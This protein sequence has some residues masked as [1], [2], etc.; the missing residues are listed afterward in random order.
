AFQLYD[1]DN[2]QT[3]TYDEMLSI[4]DAI[5]KMVGTMVK[6][7]PDEDTPEKRVSKI[8]SLMD[9]DKDGRL[10]FD[11]FKEGSMKDPTIVQ[12]LS[13]YDGLLRNTMTDKLL[14]LFCVVDGEAT[15]FSV[16]VASTD[17][18]HDLKKAVKAAKAPRF[19]DVAA[20]ELILWHISIRI[21]PPKE[22]GP[23][24][25]NEAESPTELDPSDDISEVFPEIPF[26]KT[27][28]VIVQRPP[29]D[30]AQSPTHPITIP[31]G[32]PK[33]DIK[34]ITE[35]FFAPGSATTIFL[36]RF[37][38]G[39]EKLP[40]TTGRVAGLPRVW[41]RKHAPV[42]TRP[43]LL[44]ANLP[45]SSLSDT[46]TRYPTS[47]AILEHIEKCKPSLVLIFGV[48]G[49]GK[50][51][52]M[53]ELLSRRWGF[54]FNASPKDLGSSDIT[55]L[56]DHIESRT[57][58]DRL[59]NN[60]EARIVTYLLLLSRLK[61]LQHCLAVPGS[62]QTFTSA[63]WTILQ[64]CPH[65]FN[66]DLFNLLFHTFLTLSPG[67]S[68]RSTEIDLQIALQEEIQVT[69]DLL[70]KHGRQGGLP[71]F[72]YNDN[73]LVVFDEAQILGDTL[74]GRFDSFSP[75]IPEWSLLTLV[76]EGVRNISYD[77][78]V[79]TSGNRLSIYTQTCARSSGLF[80][81]RTDENEHQYMEFP[82]WTGRE[83]IESYVVGLR[84]LL[85]TDDSK[86]ALNRLLQP[87][88]I[89]A[90]SN[91]LVGRFRPAVTA[92]ETIIA[93]G[94]SNQWQ[95][96]IDETEAHLVS[97]DH[98]QKRG[99][100]CNE[101]VRLQNKYDENV[102]PF[103]DDQRVEEVLGPLLFQRYMFGADALVFRKVIPELV[104]HGFSRIKTIDGIM[105]SVLD[106]PF[107]LKAVENYFKNQDS[108]FMKS[109][110]H[111]VMQSDKAQVH[112]YA[113]ELMMMDVLVE[114]FKTHAL[115]DW[116]HK[117]SISSQCSALKGHAL[118]VGLDEQELK[119]GIS[120]EHITMER[121]LDAHLNKDSMLDGCAVPPFFFPK[122][123]PAG[124]DIV[125]CIRVQNQLFPV[126][127]Q[128]KLRQIMTTENLR[129]AVKTASAPAV[130]DHVESLG[131]CCT[132]NKTFI[133]MMIA[134]PSEVVDKL[135]PRRGI[136]EKLDLRYKKPSDLTHVRIMIDSENI[137]EIFPKSH[138]EFLDVM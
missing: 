45:H 114:I 71:S 34:G 3:I 12:A 109:L 130:E 103:V 101:V 51:R 77:L 89:Q 41:L 60:R 15:L 122:A 19:D 13:L 43:S 32:N 49:C 73:L 38:Q 78:T 104:E 61:I 136:F 72:K 94:K 113:W 97:Y 46:Q 39:L 50:T 56:V 20:D 92:I 115:S 132:T 47:D 107:V 33:A 128:L 68:T 117:P 74:K 96:V 138:V 24:V 16:K 81:K 133:S 126:F 84:S 123:K 58:E 11:E 22:R 100:L 76:L 64:T 112:G 93:S 14:T 70:V 121:F 118:I 42:D 129:D 119:R 55:L 79:V 53:I 2:D 8:F 65:I 21:P 69:K 135:Y 98:Q 4:V 48:S 125:F 124:P 67:D 110:Q 27:I 36:D 57:Q 137:N 7:P 102:S 111:W 23:F 116:P 9:K 5:Y 134:Y 1:I 31:S 88:A 66:N 106:E 80:L 40:L 37:V 87:E 54:Y 85:P 75:R 82:G 120:H 90:M 44:F 6:L 28:H 86:Q 59:A 10:T 108:N 63:R 62:C 95:E 30:H 99:N 83:S 17:S 35:N 131:R 91:R 127:V 25:L 26:K 52:G 18:V 105:R 29:P